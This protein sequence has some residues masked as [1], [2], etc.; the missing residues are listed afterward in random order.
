MAALSLSGHD[1]D[2][3]ARG[4]A[5]LVKS[6]QNYQVILN[7]KRDYGTTLRPSVLRLTEWEDAS[8]MRLS[9]T[10]M[11]GVLNRIHLDSSVFNN[12]NVNNELKVGQKKE[13]KD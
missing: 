4:A 1:S 12:N 3:S 6:C 7:E 10:V 8:T 11:S 5:W 2:A 13:N 9:H